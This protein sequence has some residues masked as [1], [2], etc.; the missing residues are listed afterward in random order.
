MG[1]KPTPPRTSVGE[2]YNN[3]IVVDN[4]VIYDHNSA[5]HITV[6]CSCGATYLMREYSFIHRLGKGMCK[7]CAASATGPLRRLPNN[8]SA[9]TNYMNTYIQNARKRNLPFLL[10]KTE[11]FELISKNCHY[12]GSP[13][14]NRVVCRKSVAVVNGVDRYDNE[15]GYTVE[16]SVPCCAICNRA[17]GNRHGDDFIAWAKRIAS[18]KP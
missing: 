11:F 14:G 6:R 7:L 13:P 8:E 4:T 2:S 1:S 16:N 9:K 15:Q 3:L 17:K 10:S 18:F 5:R 12:C